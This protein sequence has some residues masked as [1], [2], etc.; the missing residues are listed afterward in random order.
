MV[1]KNPSENH[2]INNTG[3]FTIDNNGLFITKEHLPIS[4]TLLSYI[5]YTTD[6]DFVKLFLTNSYNI[7]ERSPSMNFYNPY[8]LYPYSTLASPAS[9]G[10][11][12]GTL[13]RGFSFSRL[14]NG[15]QKT[16]NFVNQAIPVVKQ[17]SPMM[18]N[19][20]T[21]FKVMN[22]FKKAE[23]K[24]K[25]KSKTIPVPSYQTNNPSTSTSTSNT[26][27]TFFV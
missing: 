26:G 9:T 17:V 20:K 8:M 16:L 11:L 14:L 7:L 19:A 22:E 1:K 10:I 4:S 27:P 24:E 18:K 2:L 15:A 21:M 6:F 3:N 13:E 5:D 12:G 23:P 25:Q